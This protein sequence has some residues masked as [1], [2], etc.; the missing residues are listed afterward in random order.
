MRR[1]IAGIAIALLAM[2]CTRAGDPGPPGSGSIASPPTPAAPTAPSATVA[3]VVPV[4]A[5]PEPAPDDPSLRHAVE[6]R[7]SLGLRSDLAWV[8]AV[9]A[10]PRA[11]TTYLEI[12][13]LP[14]EEADVRTRYADADTDAAA[15][16]EY[17]AG[18]ADEFGGVYIDMESGAGVVSLWTGHLED[19]EAAIRARLAPGARV[20]FRQVEYSERHLRALQDQ[21]TADRAW[22]AWIPAVM[23]SSYVDTIR[24][25]TVMSV[26]SAN[27]RA[28]VLI[29]SHYGFGNALE[30]TS[31]GTG[32]ALVPWGTVAG[33]VR[34]RGGDAPPMADYNLRWHGTGPGDCGGGDV[35]Y[36]LAEGGTFTLPCQQGTWTIEVTVP[37]GDGWRS[38]G[39]GTVDVKANRTAKLDIV[40]TAAP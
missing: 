32:A 18:H 26:S 17:A 27:P 37:S 39:E 23:L 33:R 16:N 40:L 14:A 8:E 21:V 4:P 36:G 6:L 2:A 11:T 9:A 31:D 38:I 30:V 3:V 13:L 22:M 15:V 10:D 1:G 24:N 25:V 34:T 35:G 7:R 5:S 29:E 19:H 20:A 28:V 12:P